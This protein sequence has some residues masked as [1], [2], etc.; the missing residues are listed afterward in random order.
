MH[1]ELSA[2]K[3]KFLQG[4]IDYMRSLELG[5]E[6][7]PP[8]G[9]MMDKVSEEMG[10]EKE[11][12]EMDVEISAEPEE[13]PSD[14]DKDM[15]SFFSNKHRPSFGKGAVGMTMDVEKKSPLKDILKKKKKG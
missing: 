7:A 8:M 11:I 12:P 15:K 14:M 4:L 2:A 3:L 5:K 9:E 1:D 13:E 10:D 6:E